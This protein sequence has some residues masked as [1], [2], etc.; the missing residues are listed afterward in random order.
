MY[1][2]CGTVVN[3]LDL[4]VAGSR[5]PLLETFSLNSYVQAI[6]CA[7]C[8]LKYLLSSKRIIQTVCFAILC[9]EK[10]GTA[11]LPE[12]NLSSNK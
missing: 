11:K 2:R 6:R 4:L 1:P 5:S 9:L 10:G 3:C 7:R 12:Q 8:V